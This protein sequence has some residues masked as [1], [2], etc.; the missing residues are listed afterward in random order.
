MRI[1]TRMKASIRGRATHSGTCG[2]AGPLRIDLAIL[3]AAILLSAF[4]MG[5]VTPIQKANWTITSSTHFE[6]MSTMPAEEAAALATDLERF[7]ALIYS[8]TTAPKKEPPVETKIFAFASKSQFRPFRGGSGIAGFFIPGLRDNQVALVDHSQDLGATEI[9]FHE[10]V[11]FVLRNG[12]NVTYPMWYDE[13]FAEV[14]STV[15]TYEDKLILGGLPRVRVEWFERGKWLP[16][17][18]V[19]EATRYSDFTS[20]ERGMFYAEA[21]ALAHYVTLDISEKGSPAAY[22]DRLTRGVGPAEA[23]EQTFGETIEE[24]SGDIRRRLARGDW[25]LVGIP[26][27][28][29]DYDRRTPST[30]TPAEDEVAV[31]LGYLHLS[32]RNL[33]K[34]QALFQ[35]AIESNAQNPRAHAGAGDALKFLGDWKE[36]EPHFRKAVELDPEDALNQLD[37][38]EYLHDLALAKPKGAA[39]TRLFAEAR[40]AYRASMA[41]DDGIPETPLMYGR[42]FLAPGEDPSKAV[43][44]ILRAFEV[45][46]SHTHVIQSLAEAYVASDQEDAA[47]V[48]LHRSIA[49]R[50]E[51]AV[52]GN[53]DAAIEAIRSRREKGRAE[54]DG[55]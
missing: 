15:Q 49:A 36:A 18:R 12:T 45:L 27:E 40:S 44:T 46:P 30:R 2:V 21:W 10:Y 6:I 42:T 41:L 14:L 33:R 29:L 24:S 9:I 3:F 35:V 16:M 47:R 26:L 55:P 32:R 17:K 25:K 37:L 43:D 19:I 7:R 22:L 8:V 34:A 13:G 1:E 52:L 48:V 50:E 51:G 39:R 23:Y 4:V 31:R 20:R 11:H 28:K 38:A 53:V 5:C 54:F